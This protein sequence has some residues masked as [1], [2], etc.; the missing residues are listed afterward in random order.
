MPECCNYDQAETLAAR[1]ST[2]SDCDLNRNCSLW[3]AVVDKSVQIDVSI[4]AAVGHPETTR[5]LN[6]AS[7]S[8][9][10]VPVA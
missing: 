8:L 6:Q 3:I 4:V 5:P 2:T 9:L 1:Q 10:P 7:S